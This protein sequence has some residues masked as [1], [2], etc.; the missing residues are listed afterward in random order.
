[1]KQ[2]WF[3]IQTWFKLQ[4]LIKFVVAIVAVF[5]IHLANSAPNLEIDT[6]AINALK[7]SM[8]GRHGQLAP[9]YDSGAIGLTNNGLIALRDAK[10]LPLKDRQGINAL[11][12]SENNDRNKLYL[13]IAAA[14]GHPEWSS[15]IQDAFAG[16]WID[17]AQT[18]WYYQ[19]AGGWMQK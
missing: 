1:M 16:R 11:V 17:K 5:S 13:E 8:Q 2:T 9:S 10:A 6:P 3:K 14:N 12:A 19:S 7:S 18:G 15:S 4:T